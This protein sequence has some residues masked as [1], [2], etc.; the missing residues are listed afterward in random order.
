MPERPGHSGHLKIFF[1]PKLRYV[2][3]TY[4]MKKHPNKIFCVAYIQR[5]SY[6]FASNWKFSNGFS[7]I[8]TIHVP[9]KSAANGYDFCTS[10]QGDC[11]RHNEC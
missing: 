4:G 5:H 7:F 10:D 11:D 2:T 1:I 9:I 8:E 3:K 6:L